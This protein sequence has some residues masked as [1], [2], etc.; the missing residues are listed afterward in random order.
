[1]TFLFIKKYVKGGSL[2]NTYVTSN[3]SY[4]WKSIVKAFKALSLF[5]L[6][7]DQSSLWYDH[8][9]RDIPICQRIPYVH[10]S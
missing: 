1:M 2:A 3:S 4:M 9:L 7:N 10:L 5:G 8:W 6:G